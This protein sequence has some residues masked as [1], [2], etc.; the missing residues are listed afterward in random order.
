MTKKELEDKYKDIPEIVISSIGMKEANEPIPIYKGK[1]ELEHGKSK[2]KLT[3]EILFDWFP[4]SGARFFGTV[5]NNTTYLMKSI[6]IE[7]N[8]NVLID[9]LNFGQC[10]LTNETIGNTISLEGI[11]YKEVVKGDK[12]IAVSKVIF[13]VPNLRYFFGLRVKK[14]NDKNI[15]VRSNRITFE[16]NKY[17][18]LLDKRNEYKELNK[19]LKSKGG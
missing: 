15:K 16:N 11:M 8:F 6:Q 14:I 1:F 3:G 2:M 9:G 19:S 5:D 4:S 12:S 10:S 7:K 18:I 13:A 17:I